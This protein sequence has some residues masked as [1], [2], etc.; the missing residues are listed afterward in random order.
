MSAA[1]LVKGPY[2]CDELHDRGV[3][4]SPIVRE[5]SSRLVDGLLYFET[6]VFPLPPERPSE[7]LWESASGNKRAADRHHDLAVRWFS[8]PW[9]LSS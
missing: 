3:Y 4:V 6:M 2:R 8:R 7:I 5:S 9:R 1:E